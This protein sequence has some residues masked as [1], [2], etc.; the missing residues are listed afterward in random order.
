MT[1]QKFGLTGTALKTIA[2]VLMVMD[3]IHYFFE[4]TGV[5]PEWFSMLARLSAPLFLFCTVEGFAHT[6]NRRKYF[7]RVWVIA[8][9]PLILSCDVSSLDDFTKGLL[10]NTEVLAVHQSYPV[11][12]PQ[13]R[14]RSRT[15][16]IITRETENGT[17][18]CVLNYSEQKKKVTVPFHEWNIGSPGKSGNSQKTATVR[19]LWRQRNLS[20]D[21]MTDDGF[22]VEIAGHGGELFLIR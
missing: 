18:V 11:F 5:V 2:L 15:T 20:P 1:K 14:K 9:A 22:T 7:L 16:H 12:P 4:F 21:R 17:A 6:H 3:H 19:D 8:A 13:V 10:T